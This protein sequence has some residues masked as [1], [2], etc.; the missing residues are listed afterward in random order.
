MTE[1]ELK[2]FCIQALKKVPIPQNEQEC[3]RV[4]T[5]FADRLFIADYLS[6]DNR[7]NFVKNELCSH[8]DLKEEDVKSI[9]NRLEEKEQRVNDKLQITKFKQALKYVPIYNEDFLFKGMN[10]QEAEQ[11][12]EYIEENYS[13][14][15]KQLISNFIMQDLCTHF[16]L[17]KQE[18][19]EIK[20]LQKERIK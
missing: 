20:K 3:V 16:K 19:E 8:F 9:L 14:K 18:I 1:Q 6:K 12:I 5:D 4:A 7:A 10:F 13:I 2:D 15:D 11:I 17:S